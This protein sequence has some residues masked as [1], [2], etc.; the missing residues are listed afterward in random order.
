M[1]GIKPKPGILRSFEDNSANNPIIGY[2]IIAKKLLL[3]N[4]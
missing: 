3:R 2:I 1:I 4:F